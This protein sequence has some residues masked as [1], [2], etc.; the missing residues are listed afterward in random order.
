MY[1]VTDAD[2]YIELNVLDIDEWVDS[3][4]ERKTRC[5]NV[6]SKVLTRKFPKYTIPNNAV[7]E[8]AVVLATVFSDT[9]KMQRYGV[10]SFSVKGISFTF[11]GK[12]EELEELI[13]NEAYA[14]I[15]EENGVD[16]KRRRVRV[17]WSLR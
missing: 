5:L 14:L 10:A 13:P 4:E 8:F 15:G 11:T 12:E 9:Y 7:Y 2:A 1:N 16:L 3:D 17:G 6:A